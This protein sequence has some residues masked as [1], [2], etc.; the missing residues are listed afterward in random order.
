M[1]SNCLFEAI[2]AKLKDPKNVKID[3]VSPKIN[4]GHFH[5][6]WIDRNEK[7][8]Y[9]YKNPKSKSYNHLLF[10]GTVST[11]KLEIFEAF[12]LHKCYK[13]NLTIDETI[14]YAKKHHL[15]F[16]KDDVELYYWGEEQN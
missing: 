2:K 7:R 3:Y 5:F 10:C 14:K 4:D 16:K 12:I 15:P 1:Y 11:S 6:Y 13:N 9:D 8:V